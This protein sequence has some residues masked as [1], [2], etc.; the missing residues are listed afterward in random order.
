MKVAIIYN[1]DM[2]SVINKFGMQNKE[3]YN[4]KTIRLI[5]D[6]LEQNGHNVK[7]IDGNMTVIDQLTEFMPR[8]LEGERMGMVFNL[9]Y[10][11]QG[12]SRYTHLPSLLEMLGIPY[13]GST[14]SGH[15][16]ALDKVIT[17]IILQKNDIPTPDFWVFSSAD[18]VVGDIDYPV[19]VKPKMDAV[20][21]GLRIVDND[22]DLREAVDYIIK[23][24]Q[25]QALVEK[26]I[27][28]REFCVG[29]LG[30]RGN[31]EAF[32]VLEID[33]KNDPD[34]IQ[35][36]EDKKFKPKDKICPADVEPEL[37]DRMVK[38]SKDAFGA[39]ELRDFA[40]VDIRLSET[41]EIFLLEI[42][43]MA[44][45]GRT[46]S[47]VHAAKVLGYNYKQLVNKIL[48]VAAVRY[49]YEL[50]PNEKLDESLGVYSSKIPLASRIRGF[51]R[52]RQQS[53]ER[54]LEEMVNINTQ[55][56]NIDGVNMLGALIWKQLSALG[57]HQQVIPQVLIGNLM[58]FSNTADGDF[59][60]LFIA[61]LDGS[62]SF[63]KQM[64]FKVSENKI[65]GTG[66]WE[67]KG[68]LAVLISALQALRFVRNLKKIK[69]GILITTDETL[70]G[71]FSRSLIE[72]KTVKTRLV[73]GLSGGGIEST[74]VTSRSGASV[75]K[76]EMSLADDAKTGDV[77][78][79]V[80][81]FAQLITKLAELTDEPNGL[82]VA[83]NS[84]VIDSNVSDKKADGECRVS[85]RFNQMD[86]TDIIDAKIRQLIRT[87]AK[88]KKLKLQIEGGLRRPPLIRTPYVEKLWKRIRALSK[89]MDIRLLEEH[90]WS[91]TNICFTNENAEVI[92]GLGPIGSVSGGKREYILRHSLLERA[93]LLAM[94]LCKCQEGKSK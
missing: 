58:L 89:E 76:C 44:S 85:V 21:Y 22:A 51:L 74:I 94:L 50:F 77:S 40:R 5:A 47:Y 62:T 75:Y 43:S 17:K 4:P 6:A 52:G 9:A 67:N 32:P 16:L 46:G 61:N 68:G 59:D 28:G 29:L 83:P 81:Q 70:Q 73:L 8:V 86:M 38:L 1:H 23:E 39:L 87:K 65:W 25:Q 10:G 41:N 88:N 42:N 91:S 49:S 69:V 64:P 14:P 93:G 84:V 66:V 90:R 54:L 18:D 26:F 24:F 30:N 45:L 2:S 12:E 20:S 60:V 3:M 33:L 92:D 82:V 78:M 57:F 15:A 80:A 63:K 34:A 48:E 72:E 35:S 56:R 36:V 79:A 27:R 31:L 55:T 13:V 37:R 71:R 11:I 7:V 19:I 53:T